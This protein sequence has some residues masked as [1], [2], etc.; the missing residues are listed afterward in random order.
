[1]V[2]APKATRIALIHALQES[3]QPARAAFDD[4]WPEAYCF[5]LLDTS[6]AADLVYRG[7]D[8][9][10]MGRFQVLADYAGKA[11]GQAGET[12]G[13]LFTC[14]AFGAAI[15]RVKDRLAIPVLRPN[16]AAFEEA[17]L[18]GSRFGLIVSFQP[19]LALLEAELQVAAAHYGKSIAVEGVLAEG[20]LAALRRGDAEEHDRLVAAAAKRL[21]SIEPLF[22]ASSR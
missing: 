21:G 19:S 16:E 11:I 17:L 20:V 7:L 15:D 2:E 10:I 12:A 14:S 8:E 9:T 22:S 1:M 18:L 3:V 13:I 6:L 5:D 4:I